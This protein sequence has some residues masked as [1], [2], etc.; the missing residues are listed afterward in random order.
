M[1]INF[2]PCQEGLLSSAD[3]LCNM[4]EPRAGSKKLDTLIMFMKEVFEKRSFEESQQTT[5]KA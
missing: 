5:S 1:A 2:F 4:F 3:N